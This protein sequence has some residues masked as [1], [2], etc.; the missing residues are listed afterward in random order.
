MEVLSARYMQ[1]YSDSWL[2]ALA[3]NGDKEAFGQ[4]MTRYQPMAFHLAVRLVGNRE[5]AYELVQEAMLQ[6]YLSLG[7]RGG[8]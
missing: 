3:R 4:L 2:L 6:A 5:G 1:H 8:A 7:T